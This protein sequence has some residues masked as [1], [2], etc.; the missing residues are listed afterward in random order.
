VLELTA[1]SVGVISV[2]LQAESSEKT[3][4]QVAVRFEV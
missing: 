4:W 1:D 2:I 3:A